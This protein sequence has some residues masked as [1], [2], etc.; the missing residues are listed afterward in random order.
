LARFPDLRRRLQ[1]MPG[2]NWLALFIVN[3]MEAQRWC[4]TPEAI[5]R[6]GSGGMIDI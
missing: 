6:A 4:V 5:E 1:A 2:V 3:G